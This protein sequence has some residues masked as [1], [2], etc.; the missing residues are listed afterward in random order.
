MPATGLFHTR[1][2]VSTGLLGAPVLT[3]DLVV[4]T[5]RKRVSGLARVFQSTNPPQ[6]FKAQVWGDYSELKLGNKGEAH[7]VLNL[8]G[9]PSGPLSQIAQTFHLHGILAGDWASGTA[10]YRYAINGQWQEVAHAHVRPAPTE[11]AQAQK[12]ASERT[13]S[14]VHAA[15]S[16]LESA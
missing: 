14:R 3:L 15:I 12:E 16:Q 7:I 1:L 9:S 5:P 6:N 13:R 2:N 10:S 11:T 4:D 8:A